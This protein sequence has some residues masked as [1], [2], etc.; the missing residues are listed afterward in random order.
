MASYQFDHWEDNSTSPTRIIIVTA[1]VAITAYYRQVI[2]NRRVTYGSIPIAVPATVNG[3]PVPSGNYFEVP[4]GT[5]V[6]IV[7]PSE[8]VV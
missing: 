4:D 3:Q 2:V 8:V 6:T 1:N 7:V 5:S